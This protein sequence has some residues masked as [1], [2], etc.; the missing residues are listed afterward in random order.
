MF[1]ASRPALGAWGWNV[2]VATST[3][4]VHFKPDN[5]NSPLVKRGGKGVWDETAIFHTSKP[6]LKGDTWYLFYTGRS[7]S[8]E[9]GIGYLT[10]S[11]RRFPGGWVKRTVKKPLWKTSTQG[12]PKVIKLDNIYWIYYSDGGLKR[13]GSS[14]LVHWGREEAVSSRL[15][16]FD[17]DIF[18]TKSHGRI[19]VSASTRW[20]EGKFEIGIWEESQFDLVGNTILGCSFGIYLDSVGGSTIVD[21]TICSGGVGLYL[22]GDS[23]GGDVRDNTICFNREYDIKG[24]GGNLVGG[25]TCEKLAARS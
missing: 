13:R 9:Y 8:D 3:D 16:L 17:A 21:N 22:G 6:I 19:L 23:I 1:Y 15:P 4:W 2:G 7:I 5:K 10:T 11:K 14:D 25:N 18:E 20:H 12:R 24:D